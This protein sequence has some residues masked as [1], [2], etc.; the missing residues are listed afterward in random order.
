MGAH[1]FRGSWQSQESFDLTV[2]KRRVE[3]VGRALPD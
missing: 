3:L 1:G 2:A